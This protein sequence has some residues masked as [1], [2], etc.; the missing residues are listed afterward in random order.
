MGLHDTSLALLE[1]LFS[2]ATI[3]SVLELGAQNFYQNWGSV[4]YGMYADAYYKAKGVTTYEC[5]D[6]NGENHAKV[7]DLSKPIAPF[8]VYDLVTDLGTQEHIDA[9]GSMMSLYNCWA[10]KYFA[11]SRFIVSANPK[12]GHWPKHGAYFF[13]PKFYEVLAD[14]TQMKVVRLGDQVCMGN[15]VDGVEVACVLEKTSASRWIS[16]DE[17][18]TAFAWVS[19]Q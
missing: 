11:S 18:A 10:T 9:T 2:T 16:P 8:G 19:S 7:W 5:I 15:D 17:F 14:L 6:T 4:K 13:T 1:W 12:T 3:T